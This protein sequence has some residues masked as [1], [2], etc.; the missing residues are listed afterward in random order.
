MHYSIQPREQVVGDQS[1]YT[2]SREIMH[3]WHQ[4]HVYMQ[5]NHLSQNDYLLLT[6]HLNR[7]RGGINLLKVPIFS[8]RAKKG[9]KTGSVTLSGSHTVGATSLTITGGGG[10]FEPGDWIWIS[11]TTDVPRAYI[12]TT[13]QTGSVIGI[14]PGLRVAHAGGSTVHHFDGGQILDTMELQSDP[15]FGNAMPSPLPGLFEPFAVEFL[16]ALRVSP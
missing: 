4:W 16:S 2:G 5:W 1:P 11:Q 13:G 3:R 9:N 14:N 7:S 10:L 8:Y 15:M 12:I 6:A